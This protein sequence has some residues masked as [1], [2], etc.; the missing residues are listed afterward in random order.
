MHIAGHAYDVMSAQEVD[1]IHQGA[2]CILDEMGMEVQNRRLLE[3]LAGSGLRV[4]FGNERAHF[5]PPLVERFI[6][7]ADKYDWE[8]AQPGVSGSAGVYHG[9]YH[10]PDSGEL[11]PWTE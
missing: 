8:K 2:L 1:L 11:V 3:V 7:G 10:D 4:D 5:P 6:A 9:L